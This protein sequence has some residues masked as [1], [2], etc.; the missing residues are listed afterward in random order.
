[1][2]SSLPGDPA[3]CFRHPGIHAPITEQ[4]PRTPPSSGAL[5]PGPCGWCPRACSPAVSGPWELTLHPHFSR[6]L[7][8]PRSPV[9][10]CAHLTSPKDP[11]FTARR[12]SSPQALLL[13]IVTHM[14]PD[15]AQSPLASERWSLRW[16]FLK[17]ASTPRASSWITRFISFILFLVL[18]CGSNR[19]LFIG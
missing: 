3:S 6:V 14:L 19:V 2:P 8:S 12:Q 5:L 11:A 7:S 18:L 15:L 16:A 9:H 4:D 13:P 1:M 17:G 10:M